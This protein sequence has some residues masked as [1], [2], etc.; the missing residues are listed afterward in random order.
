MA[1]DKDRDEELERIFIEKANKV[2]PGSDKGVDIGMSNS[3]GSGA[4]TTRGEDDFPLEPD[5]GIGQVG[6]AGIEGLS[7][8][9]G[10]DSPTPTY[11]TD[12]PGLTGREP[13]QTGPD[14]IGGGRGNRDNPDE[15]E[16]TRAPG[17]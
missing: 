2:I 6:D 9:K 7:D 11:D 10:A 12:L 1:A 17:M 14:V 8:I 16:D 4:T 13:A 3:P 15:E 5:T